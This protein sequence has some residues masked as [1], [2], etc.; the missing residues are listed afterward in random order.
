MTY[1]DNDRLI[2]TPLTFQE[3]KE[4]TAKDLETIAKHFI[5][6]AAAAREGDMD[7]VE[8]TFLSD[9]GSEDT[10]KMQAL[11]E[12]FVLRYV[13]REERTRKTTT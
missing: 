12:I 8:A 5:D 2:N 13:H 1:E 11:R 9:A 10:A 3:H 7:R 4:Q 6:L